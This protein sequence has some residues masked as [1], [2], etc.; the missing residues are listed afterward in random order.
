NAPIILI[1][2]DLLN[3][4]LKRWERVYSRILDMKLAQPN[5]IS[6]A[7]HL[8]NLYCRKVKIADDLLAHIHKKANGSARR[9]CVNLEEIQAEALSRGMDKINLAE[10]KEIKLFNGEAPKRGL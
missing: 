4:K 5:D 1:G 2:E 6:D 9:I 3:G 7:Q 10:A 8:R